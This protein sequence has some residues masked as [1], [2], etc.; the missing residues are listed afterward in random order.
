MEDKTLML[1]V[2]KNEETYFSC[3]FI[4]FLQFCSHTI[5]DGSIFIG[6]LPT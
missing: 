6:Q 2:T 5:G 1:F 3:Y 4:I